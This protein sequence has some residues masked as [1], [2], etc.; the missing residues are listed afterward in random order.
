MLGVLLVSQPP[1][2]LLHLAPLAPAISSASAATAPFSPAGFASGLG[3]GACGGLL[4]VL[5]GS[6]GLRAASPALLNA[7][8]FCASL[9]FALLALVA[10]RAP[11]LGGV[12]LTMTVARGLA[13]VG[14]LMAGQSGARTLGLQRAESSSVATLLYSEIAWCFALELL[15]R[16]AGWQKVGATLD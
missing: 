7:W 1:L 11:L 4:N 10:R 12:A 5:L 8:Q 9:L 15:V 2:P 13:L 6:A 14:V 16:G 3:F